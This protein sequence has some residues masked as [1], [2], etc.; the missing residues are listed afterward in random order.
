MEEKDFMKKPLVYL[1]TAGLA[2][3]LISSGT[4]YAVGPSESNATVNFTAP[5]NN[6]VGP[7]DPTDPSQPNTDDPESNGNITGEEG[8]L[9]LDYVSHIDFGNQEI[10][11]TEGIYESTTTEPY[12]QVTDVRGTG[13]GWDVTAQASNFSTE[14]DSASLP[15]STITLSNGEAASAAGLNEP[16]V[17]SEI[18]LSTG[19]E[20]ANVVSAEPRVA[21]EPV[22]TAEGLGTWVTRWLAGEGSTENEN[23]IL[24]VPASTATAGTHTATITWTLS[25]GPT[26]E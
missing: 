4:T 21:E 15:G 12:I 13:A 11:T 3:S 1:L 14:G 10:S 5:E 7:V 26:G 6:T 23:V 20:A 17:E 8:P 9:S 16:Y 22:N 18:E 2:V 19:G 24:T 25:T